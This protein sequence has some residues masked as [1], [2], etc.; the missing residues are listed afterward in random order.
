M[1]TTLMRALSPDERARAHQIR[2]QRERDERERRLAAAVER[3]EA[4][5][6][7]LKALLRETDRE[8]DEEGA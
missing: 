4:E 5:V 1:S 7:G 8:R 2:A 6:R 3:L